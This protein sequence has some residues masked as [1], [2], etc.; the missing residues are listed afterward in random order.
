[1]ALEPHVFLSFF[2]SV[3][4]K[5]HVI[6]V[7]LITLKMPTKKTRLIGY[8]PIVLMKLFEL[9]MFQLDININC[10][11]LGDI[12]LLSRVTYVTFVAKMQKAYKNKPCSTTLNVLERFRF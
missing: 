11:H 3:V 1:M 9:Y 7:T 12:L 2:G 6:N 5:W 8:V 4:C 10:K